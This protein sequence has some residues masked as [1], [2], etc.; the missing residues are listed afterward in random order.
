MIR[1]RSLLFIPALSTHLLAKAASRGA[2]ALI[3]D[4]E[5]SIPPDRK[6]QARPA[7]V[8]AVTTLVAQGQCV[9]L[10]VNR[11]PDDW[12]R[13][14][15][16]MP[17][18]ALAAV[19]LPKTQSAAEVDALATA[20]AARHAR[21]P[22]V[23]PLI[24][25]PR[26]LL[27]AADIAAHPAVV[28]LGYG[29]EDYAAAIG[30]RATPVAVGVPAYQVVAAAHAFGR[31]CIGLPASIGDIADLSAFEDAVRMARAIGF[32]GSVCIHPRQVEVLNRGFSP[33]A[34]ELDRARR[35]VAA[36]EAARARGQG[37]FVFEGRLADG[38]I[39]QH[40]RR[41]LESASPSPRP[42]RDPV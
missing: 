18:G 34:D 39:V 22:A 26:G 41:L 19:M 1:W 16:D 10:R 28:A 35:L 37:A 27:A 7:A 30:V 9:L 24:E 15:D 33:T 25:N 42:D 4:L 6:A 32:T 20:L 2:D 8:L 11:D 31:Q 14:I 36:D 21:P 13:D 23:V 12:R 3:I 29:A 5:D 38:P 17:D 40:A